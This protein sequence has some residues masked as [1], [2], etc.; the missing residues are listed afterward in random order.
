MGLSVAFFRISLSLWLV[1]VVVIIFW[2][3]RLIKAIYNITCYAEI[4]SFYISALNI[5]TVNDLSFT[6]ASLFFHV[7]QDVLCN[8]FRRICRTSLGM[9]CKKSFSACKRSTTYPCNAR[10]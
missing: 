2:L 9:K 1:L 6:Q 4:R 5:Q 8:I 10:T 3:F 7:F